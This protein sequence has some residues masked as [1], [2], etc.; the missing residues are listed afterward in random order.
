MRTWAKHVL[1]AT[2]WPAYP[3]A[4][5]IAGFFGFHAKALVDLTADATRQAAVA[6]LRPVVGL[7]FTVAKPPLLAKPPLRFGRARVQTLHREIGGQT[8]SADD[9]P[10][11]R[12]HRC[13][14]IDAQS[15]SQ[16]WRIVRPRAEA[17]ARG[18]LP[19]P[20]RLCGRPPSR[21]SPDLDFWPLGADVVCS[22]RPRRSLQVE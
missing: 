14:I 12:S 10:R 5:I 17:A 21:R 8:H 20:S 22:S 18:T 15:T 7:Y 3:T 16:V 2:T 11:R 1:A 4:I 19:W 9:H 6:K 13:R